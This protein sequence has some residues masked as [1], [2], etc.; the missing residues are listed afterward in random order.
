MAYSYKYW[1]TFTCGHTQRTNSCST[2]DWMR[3]QSLCK[4]CNEEQ[5]MAI[6]TSVGDGPLGLRS[7]SLWQRETYRLRSIEITQAL[8]RYAGYSHPIPAEWLRELQAINTH[9]NKDKEE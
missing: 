9:L 6:A 2:W 4:S 3:Q 1:H 8:Q 5:N 7:V